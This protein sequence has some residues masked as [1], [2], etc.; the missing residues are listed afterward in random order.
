MLL[1]PFGDC[2]PPIRWWFMNNS[3]FQQHRR[4]RHRKISFPK[5][6]FVKKSFHYVNWR[7]QRSAR[8]FIRNK[9]EFSS[10]QFPEYLFVH[11][12]NNFYPQFLTIVKFSRSTHHPWVAI[13]LCVVNLK[14]EN[15]KKIFLVVRGFFFWFREKPC[16]FHIHWKHATHWNDEKKNRVLRKRIDDPKINIRAPSPNIANE[17]VIM[18]TA[19]LEVQWILQ[20]LALWLIALYVSNKLL[21]INLYQ[22]KRL[23]HV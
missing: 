5:R 22:V 9:E 1:E 13:F 23:K 17:E 20:S 19:H 15:F 6:T 10:F 4:S 14:I 3:E 12:A 16:G 11:L 18:K 7:R 8:L 21:F 2:F